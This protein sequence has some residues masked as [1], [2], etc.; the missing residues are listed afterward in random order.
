M[1][2]RLPSKQDVEGSIPFSR[3]NPPF[4]T[5]GGAH[6]VRGPEHAVAAW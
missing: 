3:S 1:V 2:E 5:C 6:P 4:S